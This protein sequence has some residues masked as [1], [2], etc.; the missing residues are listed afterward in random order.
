MVMRTHFQAQPAPRFGAL[1]FQQLVDQN[2]K[3]NKRK[4]N[5]RT[6]PV[7]SYQFFGDAGQTFR[8]A[9]GK[10]HT[11]LPD[12]VPLYLRFLPPTHP[13][14]Q[15]PAATQKRVEVFQVPFYVQNP[16]TGL[17]STRP[18]HKIVYKLD[19]Q[20]LGLETSKI[21]P[22]PIRPKPNRNPDTRAQQRLTP[23]PTPTDSHHSTECSGGHPPHPA[24]ANPFAAKTP[25]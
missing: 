7:R 15:L 22:K 21:S 10:V 19:G 16:T 12:N 18:S 5:G 11:E 2:A 4:E 8:L 17:F 25:S 20:A 14:K 1:R 3:A 24:D 23:P 6:V 9:H 13:V